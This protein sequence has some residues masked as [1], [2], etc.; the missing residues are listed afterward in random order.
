M[1][2]NISIGRAFILM[3]NHKNLFAGMIILGL[4]LSITGCGM[5]GTKAKTEA[6]P[7]QPTAPPPPSKPEVPPTPSAAPAVSVPKEA[8]PPVTSAAPPV[9][10]KKE[11]AKPSPPPAPTEIYVITLKN[12]N[13]RAE[14]DLKSK[15]ITTLKKGT[16]VEKIG[17][18]GNWANVKLPSGETGYIFHELVKELE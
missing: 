9:E 18:S 1:F 10:P 16:K 8:Q 17:Q 11:E 2:K 3:E 12:S 4:L 6:P 14:P 7:A 13:V 5:L 15:V